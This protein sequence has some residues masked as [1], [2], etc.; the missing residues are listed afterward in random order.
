MEENKLDIYA[1]ALAD[2]IIKEQDLDKIKNLTNLFNINQHKKNIVRTTKLNE[3]LDAITDQMVERFQKKPNEF[4]NA[5]LLDYL[6]AVQN[7][8]DKANKNTAQEDLQPIQQINNTQININNEEQLSKEA[9]DRVLNF[10]KKTI[11]SKEEDTVE[12]EGKV[13]DE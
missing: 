6:T 5:D 8:I 4:S 13:E 2:D 9:R 11:N 10:I 3:L 1:K 12:I 7:T